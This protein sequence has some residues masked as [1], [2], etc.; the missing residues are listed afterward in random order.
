MKGLKHN[1]LG[2]PYVGISLG[3]RQLTAVFDQSSLSRSAPQGEDA[4]ASTS[5]CTGMFLPMCPRWSGST[6]PC[7]SPSQESSLGHLHP[8]MSATTQDILLLSNG[9]LSPP[10]SVFSVIRSPAKSF[11]LVA[12]HTHHTTLG[13]EGKDISDRY[14][15][16]SQRTPEWGL[17][18]G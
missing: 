16:K 8:T 3:I 12:T 10:Y 7:Q 18:V 14:P 13:P 15:R 5:Q 9:R 2:L 4:S 6:P 11:Q 17:T 1:Q